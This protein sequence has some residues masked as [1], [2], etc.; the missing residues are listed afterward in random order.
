MTRRGCSLEIAGI[1]QIYFQSFEV[2]SLKLYE[3]YAAGIFLVPVRDYVSH[4]YKVYEKMEF[5]IT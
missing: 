5:S 3:S 1:T 2:S 4:K